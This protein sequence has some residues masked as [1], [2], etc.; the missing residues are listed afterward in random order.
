MLVVKLMDTAGTLERYS[1]TRAIVKFEI[2]VLP[3]AL[4]LTGRVGHILQTVVKSTTGTEFQ[5]T[6]GVEL[7]KTVQ[8]S[9]AFGVP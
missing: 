1:I 6:S 9:P 4:G 5:Y 2:N 8:F 7:G 3:S